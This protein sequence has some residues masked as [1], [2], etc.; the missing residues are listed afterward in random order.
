MPKAKPST[1]QTA[2]HILRHTGWKFVYKH[3]IIILIITCRID[4]FS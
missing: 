4:V 2:A 3:S 1:V